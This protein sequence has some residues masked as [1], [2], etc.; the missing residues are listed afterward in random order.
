MKI[1]DDKIPERDRER[2]SERQRERAWIGK[3]LQRKLR[4]FVKKT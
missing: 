1:T 4:T 2:E 3:L